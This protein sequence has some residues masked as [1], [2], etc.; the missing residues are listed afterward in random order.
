MHASHVDGKGMIPMKSWALL[1]I[2]LV[3]CSS[4]VDSEVLGKKGNV[5]GA[6]GTGG[7]GETTKPASALFVATDV[8]I[9]EV[10]LFQGV[11]LSL[12]KDGAAGK[13]T[14]ASAVAGRGGLVRVYLKLGQS[15][16]ARSLTAELTLRS[17]DGT[18]TIRQSKLTVS[19]NSTDSSL[20][21]T[22]N[23]TL[24][25]A[26]IAAGSSFKVRILNDTL[27]TTI[28]GAPAQYPD[29]NS[30][31]SFN[32]VA[33]GKLRVKL[34][35]VRYDADGSGRLPDT[36]A[37]QVERYR[38]AFMEQYP[39]TD[40][41]VTVRDAIAWT[42]AIGANGSGFDDVL[43]E[44]VYVR[45]SDRPSSD[46]Y[47][48][49]IFAP[50]SSFQK[51]CGG[52]CV[53]GLSGLVYNASD[54]QGRASVGVGFSGTSSADTSVHEVGHAHGRE[55]SP[56]GTSGSRNYPYANGAIGSWGYGILSKKLYSSTSY[57]DFMGYCNP[58]WVSD[59]TYGALLTRVKAVSPLTKSFALPGG[60]Y[61]FVKINADGNLRWGRSVTL[62][63][64]PTNTPTAIRAIEGNGTIRNV[65]GY[66]YPFAE[67]AG[68]YML[69]R[70]S[71]VSG[72]RI[73]IDLEGATRTLQ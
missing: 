52:G 53:T 12:M 2:V 46:V 27:I 11:K 67:T 63:E 37:E 8:T 68:G 40:V 57:S 72:K 61:R 24:A 5:P 15:Y 38:T 30:V 44:M 51:Y 56:C 20:T 33:S 6:A 54:S 48:M 59:Y 42:S 25:A 73:E 17:P 41:E 4:A 70:K 16:T 1:P 49:G 34:V 26:D 32:A 18:D 58:T 31:A 14:Y 39:V 65:T 21:S 7:S 55:H 19:Q 10:A 22:L 13:N 45:A 60:E 29:D 36:S 28:E 9:T 71:D 3:G 50:T 47:Y 35:P 66:Y 64:A 69:V 62:P 43:E 23:F